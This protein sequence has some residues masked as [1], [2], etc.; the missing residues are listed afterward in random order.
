MIFK[1]RTLTKKHKSSFANRHINL[2]HIASGTF[3]NSLHN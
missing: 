3:D 2:S 1:G